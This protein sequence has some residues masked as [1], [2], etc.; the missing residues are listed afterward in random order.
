M[1][2]K[3]KLSTTAITAEIVPTTVTPAITPTSDRKV[4]FRATQRNT[5]GLLHA[6]GKLGT[7]PGCTTGEGGCAQKSKSGKTLTC[8]V[9]GLVKCYKG[10]KGVLVHNSTLLKFAD[11]DTQTALL[12]A[13][14]TRF[15]E[16]ERK[17][18]KK[19][20]V[21]VGPLLRYRLHWSGDV[22][23]LQ[24]ARALTRAMVM[25]PEVQ[26][27]GYTRSFV[28]KSIGAAYGNV[29]VD[30]VLE[31]LEAPNMVL[32][33][34]LDK[35]NVLQG[36]LV[37]AKLVLRNPTSDAVRRLKLCYMSETDDF[38]SMC[39]LAIREVKALAKFRPLGPS[40]TMDPDGAIKFINSLRVT[41]CPVDIGVLPL[42]LGCSKCMK[43]LK[44]GISPVI[45]FKS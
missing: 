12:N 37:A 45:W 6:K 5:F 19:H 25:H 42:E 18:A 15:E 22:F 34:S 40:L 17:Y 2:T 1:D 39:E 44:P 10:I 14:F 28:S 3:S 16:E 21:P 11:E 13:E 8:Y 43:C 4:K 23:S 24:Y 36:I 41:P 27:W 7:C 9:D 30:T 33:L 20:N 38:K 32:H 35:V 31:L 29:G 26:F